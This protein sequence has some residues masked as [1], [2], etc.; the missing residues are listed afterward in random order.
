MSEEKKGVAKI[1]IEME[2]NE[3]L[4]DLVKE[5]MTKMPEMAKMFQRGG[6]HK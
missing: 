3:A 6:E 2:L 5:T 4:M 1:T